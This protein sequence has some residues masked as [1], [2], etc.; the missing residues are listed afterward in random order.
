MR[1]GIRSSI[2]AAI[3]DREPP[4]GCHFLSFRTPSLPQ[5]TLPKRKMPA[6]TSPVGTAKAGGKLLVPDR[7]AIKLIWLCQGIGQIDIGY[8]FFFIGTWI[9]WF[10]HKE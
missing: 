6:F 10:V 1:C 5:H 2:S 4:A 9:R 7:R 3:A 8:Y